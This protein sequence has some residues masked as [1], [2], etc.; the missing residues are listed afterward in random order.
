M[1]A[2]LINRLRDTRALH[3]VGP[4]AASTAPG[5][6]RAPTLNTMNKAMG[7]YEATM[8]AEGV[9]DAESEQQ[10][11]EAWGLLI[12]T[13]MAWQLQ[14]WFGRAANNLIAQGLIDNEG[15]VI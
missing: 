4:V 13:G 3:R 2:A 7:T 12:R 11:L 5:G 6:F 14:G 1:R 10:Y 15:N 8:I 9:Q